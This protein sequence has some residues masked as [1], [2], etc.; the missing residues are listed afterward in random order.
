MKKIE[1]TIFAMDHKY[2][3]TDDGACFCT[4]T[5]LQCLL[6]DAEYYSDPSEWEED[7]LHLVKSAQRIVKRLKKEQMKNKP[8]NHVRKLIGKSIQ[9]MEERE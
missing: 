7:E 8:H 4:P 2:R 6:E 1:D 3:M 9:L 5:N